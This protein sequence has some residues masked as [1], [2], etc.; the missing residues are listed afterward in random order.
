MF[1]HVCSVFERVCDV[2]DPAGQGAKAKTYFNVRMDVD[3][4]DFA[5][6]LADS[7]AMAGRC[8]RHAVR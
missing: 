4:G 8:A 1:D 7:A 5:Y 3:D 6:M 2:F